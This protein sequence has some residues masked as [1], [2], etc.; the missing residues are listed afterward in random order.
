MNRL[1]DRIVGVLLLVLAIGYGL[2]TGSFTSGFFSD[3]LGPAAFPR[4]L[5]ILLGIASLYLILRPDPD[6]DWP[7]GRALI[8]QLFTVGVLVAYAFLLE[9]LGFLPTTFIALMVIALQ[10]GRPLGAAALMG[11]LGALGLFILFDLLL[12]LNLPLG[13]LFGD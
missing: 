13:S 2:A 5:A 3:S 4:L 12:G 6:A 9:L 7:R 1:S 11:A 8:H 10:L